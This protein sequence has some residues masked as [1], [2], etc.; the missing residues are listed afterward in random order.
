MTHSTQARRS[1]CGGLIAL[2][3][4]ALAAGSASAAGFSVSPIRLDFDRGTRTGV[5]TVSNEDEQPLELEM[6]PMEWT[7]GDTGND[8]YQDS[9][10]LIFF[11]Q[12]MTVAPGEQ[13]L[14]RVGIKVPA[15]ER[16]KTYRLFI[17]QAPRRG[18]AAQ[19]GAQVAIR[20]RFGVPI[21]VK[22]LKEEL[23]PE[24]AEAEVRGGKLQLKVRN[25]GNAHVYFESIAAAGADGR[26]AEARGWYV[27]AGRTRAFE[28]P[29]SAELCRDARSLRASAQ[30]E[31]QGKKLKLETEVPLAPASCAP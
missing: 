13:R 10:D 19:Q 11:P 15:A 29:L 30:Y 14:I 5:I 9:A 24:I 3:C 2:A 8:D 1:A 6:Q 21:F 27:L 4:A 7:Q 20:V 23:K 25:N 26:S 18:E 12:R 31:A 22:P 28:V 17:Q 16:E